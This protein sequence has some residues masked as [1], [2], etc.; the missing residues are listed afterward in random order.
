ME[1]RVLRA[2]PPPPP[3]FFLFFLPVLLCGT[4]CGRFSAIASERTATHLQAV[5]VA[6]KELCKKRTQLTREDWRYIWR[7]QGDWRVKHKAITRPRVCGVHQ[8]VNPLTNPPL[9]IPE[10]LVDQ[11]YT[12]L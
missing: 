3:F 5:Y 4:D 12:V 8:R 6:L 1:R 9:F 11:T 10:S 7:V 2:I